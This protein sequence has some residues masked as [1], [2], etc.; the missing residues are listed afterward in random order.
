MGK[1]ARLKAQRR[2]EAARPPAGPALGPI[3]HVAAHEAGHAVVQWTLGLPFDYVSLDTS[4][5]GVRPLADVKKEMGDTWLINAAGC[6]ADFQLRGL[7]LPD[8]EILKLLLGS[9]DGLFSAVDH[10]G[11][12]AVRPSRAPAVAPGGD[13]HMM[14]VVMS[15]DGDGVPWPAAEI[16][17]VWRDCESYVAACRGPIEAVAA[18]LLRVRKLT[19]AA[20]GV[21]AAGATDGGPIP[22]LPQW[23]EDAQQ[24]SRH[25]EASERQGS[26]PG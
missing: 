1:A 24:V 9:P 18:E 12:V 8:P 22:P 16:I 4:P 25:I 2:R 23:F 26:L 21:V 7:M 3:E 19:Y 14:A 20:T 6:I 15:D 13:L 17:G 11:R 5:P 10:S